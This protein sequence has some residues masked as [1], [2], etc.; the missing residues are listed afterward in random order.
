MQNQL[1]RNRKEK[2]IFKLKRD[3]MLLFVSLY[4]I[5]YVNHGNTRNFINDML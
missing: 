1:E 5:I 2:E 3:K 4:I